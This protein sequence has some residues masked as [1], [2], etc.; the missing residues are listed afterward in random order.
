MDRKLTNGCTFSLGNE[1]YVAA[2]GTSYEGIGI[3]P[4]IQT[5]VFTPAELAGHRES[6]LDTPGIS[7]TPAAG[8]QTR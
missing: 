7:D 8:P 3:P 5:P 2:N 4:T 1:N 6:A